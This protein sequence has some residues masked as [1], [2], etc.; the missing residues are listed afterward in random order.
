MTGLT[1]FG[2]RGFVLGEYVKQYYHH[3]IGNIAS[4]NA[5]EDYNVYSEDVLYGI[6]TVS[7]H[8]IFTDLHVDIDTNL[9]VFVDVLRNWKEYQERTRTKGVFN[10]L[11]SWSVYGEQKVLPVPETA[12]CCNQKGFY[13]ITKRTAEQLL[14]SY[15]ETFGL[16]YRILRL[17]NI[18]G[19]DKKAGATKNGL[20]YAIQQLRE[21]KDA[22]L[23][24]D[25][26]FHRDFMYVTDAN[27][28]IETVISKGNP[29][30]I[31]NI[32]N[33]LTWY[34]NSIMNYAVQLLNTGAKV[35]YVEPTSFQKTTPISSFYMDVTKL[36]SLGFIPE[37]TD[38]KLYRAVILGEGQ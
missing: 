10:F 35:V 14:I 6:S 11:S 34:Y 32:G 24:G 31:F 8:H 26:M 9:S 7:N 16:Q 5:R 2:G 30:D 13:I 23:Y 22:Q 21:G 4:I 3:A 33:G 19:P 38:N 25:G 27:R 12:L 18:L 28:A 29:N 20:Q 17:C 37:Y 36:K 15:C 1:I